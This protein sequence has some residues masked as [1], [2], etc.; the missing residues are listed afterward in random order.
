MRE[1]V[2]INEKKMLGGDT[3]AEHVGL[4]GVRVPSNGKSF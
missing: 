2:V 1:V 4:G 3:S